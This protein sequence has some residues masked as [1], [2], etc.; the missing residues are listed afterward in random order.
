MEVD[1]KYIINSCPTIHKNEKRTAIRK[2]QGKS[3]RKNMQHHLQTQIKCDKQ[4]WAE[5]T[6]VGISAKKSI[7]IRQVIASATREEEKSTEKRKEDEE[8]EKEKNSLCFWC[9]L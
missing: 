5:P 1:L 9:P 7:I 8:N 6:R 4:N 3:I 2:R